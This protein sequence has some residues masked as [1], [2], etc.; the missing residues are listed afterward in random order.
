M[1][2]DPGYPTGVNL[3][4]IGVEEGPELNEDGEPIIQEDDEPLEE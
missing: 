3:I 2:Q 4:E 1:Y